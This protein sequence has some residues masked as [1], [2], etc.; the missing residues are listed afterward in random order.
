MANLGYIQL[1][2]NPGLYDLAV[3]AGRSSEV[4]HLES[5][6]AT[7]LKSANVSVTGSQVALTTMEGLTI[8]PRFARNPGM[9]EIL[10]LLDE[11]LPGKAA[12]APSFVDQMKSK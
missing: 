1:K 7:G 2:A 10:D 5:V 11:A 3:R 8:Y 4:F 6:G 9:E 12:A